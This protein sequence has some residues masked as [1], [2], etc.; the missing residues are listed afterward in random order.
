MQKADTNLS[1]QNQEKILS[2]QVAYWVQHEKYELTSSLI[3][4]CPNFCLYI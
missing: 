1:S 4:D 2:K 3:E